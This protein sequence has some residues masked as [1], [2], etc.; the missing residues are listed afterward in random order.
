MVALLG[1][2]LETLLLLYWSLAS[3]ASTVALLPVP[4]A[5][6][7]KCDT[8]AAVVAAPAHLITPGSAAQRL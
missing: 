8:V 4:G 7:F 2:H 6:G 3:F 1:E 5:S